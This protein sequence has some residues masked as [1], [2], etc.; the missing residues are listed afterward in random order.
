VTTKAA[1]Q[2]ARQLHLR[3]ADALLVVD[4]QRDFL[5]G[6]SLAVP[7]SAAVIAPLNAYI[8]AFDTRGLPIFFARDWHPADHCSFARQGGRWPVHCVQGTPGAAF[9][10]GLDV[11][12]AD[13]II[14]KGTDATAEAYSAFSGTK[15]SSLLQDLDVRRV[16]VGGLATDY[17]VLETVADARAQGL[18]V[19]VLEDAIRAVNAQPGDERHALQQILARGAAM[20]TPSGYSAAPRDHQW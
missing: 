12:P 13:P 4:V 3:S 15:L 10:E 14:S 11:R 7:D 1:S 9:A 5:P 20:F 6:G 2:L 17:C 18:D 19:V 16:F 8:R